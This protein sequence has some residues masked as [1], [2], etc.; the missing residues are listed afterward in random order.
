[1]STDTD[2]PLYSAAMWDQRYSEEEFAF[3]DA[4]NDFLAENWRSIPQGSVLCV[5]E[6][7]GRNGVF[8]AQQGYRVTG[9]DGS[10]AGLKKA[11]RLAESRGVS[12]HTITADLETFEILPETFEGVVSIFAHLPRAVR[13]KLHRSIVAGLKPGGVFLLEAYTPEQADKGTGGPSR[14]ELLMELDTLREELEGL[15]VVI[16]REL[17][18]EVVEGRYHTGSAHVVQFLARKTA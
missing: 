12:I 5:A 15:E 1:M 6:G 11:Q 16:G 17:V 4:P 3:G 10:E 18:R 13:Q 14:P 9:V 8:L 7:E 2:K